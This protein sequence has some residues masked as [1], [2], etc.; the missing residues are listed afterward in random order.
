MITIYQIQS[1]INDVDNYNAGKEVKAIDARRKVSLSADKF[2]SSML[3]Y[4]SD[5]F[6]VYTDDLDKAFELTN[7]FN[8][9]TK[10]DV[11]GDNPTSS[12]VGDIF[13]LNERFYM[14]D[15]FGFKELR[16][17]DDEVA[18]LEGWEYEVY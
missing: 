10:I 4:Y 15:T 16:L 11:I 7:L 18:M 12:S 6:V 8:D 14:V 1:S 5:A 17:F 2:E 9:Q 13:R 3:E